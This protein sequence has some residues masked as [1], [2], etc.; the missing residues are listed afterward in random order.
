MFTA[1]EVTSS[2]AGKLSINGLQSNFFWLQKFKN[3]NL[4]ST[5]SEISRYFKSTPKKCI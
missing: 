4:S 1:A 3:L 5:K 2:G